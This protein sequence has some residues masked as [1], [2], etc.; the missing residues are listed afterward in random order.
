VSAL[1]EREGVARNCEA[2]KEENRTNMRKIRG[3]GDEEESDD[4]FS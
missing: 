3:K 4:E 2:I 1:E